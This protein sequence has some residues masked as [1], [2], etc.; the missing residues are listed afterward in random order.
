MKSTIAFSALLEIPPKVEAQAEITFPKSQIQ[1]RPVA[2]E[3]L[4]EKELM[5]EM[6][7]MR[8]GP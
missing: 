6:E 1:S 4:N 3:K 5:N 7:M 2:R 8:F